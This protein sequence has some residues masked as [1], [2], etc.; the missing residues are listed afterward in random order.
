MN[1]VTAMHRETLRQAISGVGAIGRV[2]QGD[3]VAR[4]NYVRGGLADAL[5][6]LAILAAQRLEYMEV[7][8]G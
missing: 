1:N 3:D 7:D 6:A 4:D 5:E 2:L 8:D